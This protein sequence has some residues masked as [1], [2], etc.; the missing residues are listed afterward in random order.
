MLGDVRRGVLHQDLGAVER[1]RVT[2]RE[3]SFDDDRY[4]G[5]EEL[6]RGAAT[7]DVDLARA[8]SGH[9]ERR[10]TRGAR[11]RV[12]LHDALESNGGGANLGA[13]GE[14]LVDGVE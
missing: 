12:G 7:D 13:T 3:V 10:A 11:D 8:R 1:R 5:L 4:V 9:P 6:R 2:R 14:D